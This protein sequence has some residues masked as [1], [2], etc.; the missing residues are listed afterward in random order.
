M[1]TLLAIYQWTILASML[2][3]SA[4]ALLGC[5][6][7]ARDK[8]MQTLCIGQGATLGVLIGI[9][10][11]RSFAV[12]EEVVHFGPLVT[13]TLFS[14]GAYEIGEMWVERHP[15]SKTTLFTALFTAL[16]ALGYLAIALFPTLENH[17]TQ[18]F[19]GDLATLCNTD[20]MVTCFLATVS[21]ALLTTYWK[22]ISNESFEIASFGNLRATGT[23]RDRRISRVFRL[24]VLFTLCYSIQ[25]L[26]FLF[27]TTCL[28]TPTGL[29]RFAG[30]RRLRQHFGLGVLV[31]MTSTLVGFFISL[32]A[33]RLPTVPT[34]VVVM[35]IELGGIIAVTRMIQ[36]RSR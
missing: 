5:H 6:L 10:F 7:A 28:F 22:P 30:V 19:F 16:L 18:L 36:H 25:F 9:G 31:A 33:T 23:A 20:A 24:L 27:T 2:A 21:F 1:M 14:W 13:A 3:G 32:S 4:L 17:M 26:G 11:L 15:A 29:L 8:A 12:H 35:L 34:I